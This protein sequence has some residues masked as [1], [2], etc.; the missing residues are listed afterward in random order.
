MIAAYRFFKND[1][2]AMEALQAAL[3]DPIQPQVEG[4]HVLCIQDTTEVNY[5]AHSGRLKAS[6]PELG[7]V[8]NDRDVGFFLHPSLVLDAA[9]GFALG[10][11][12]VHLWNRQWDK[13]DKH[14]RDYKRLPIEQKESFRWIEAAQQA[15]LQLKK[16]AQVTLI[17]DREADI[18]QLFSR[19]ADAQMQLLIRSR[20]E[21]RIRVGGAEGLLSEH[22]SGLDWVGEIE[23]KIRGNNGRRKR[24]ACLRVRFSRVALLRP[25]L[26]K[27]EPVDAVG[28]YVV[29]VVERAETVPSGEEPIRWC[30]LTTHCI[31][32]LADALTMIAYYRRRWQIEQ[33]FRLLKSESLELE[34]SQLAHGLALKKLCIMSLHVA[35]VQLQLVT[36][37]SGSASVAASLVFRDSALIF[38]GV[39]QSE[40]EGKTKKQ[41]CSHVEGTLAWGSWVIGRLG[42]WKGYA[43]QSPPG[44]ITMRRGLERFMSQF[45]GWQLA[46]VVQTK[47]Y[48]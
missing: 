11:A 23:I 16:A 4:K 27:Q 6:D 3:V 34:S 31:L 2:I 37:R 22:L 47:G 13:L 9:S 21:R 40:L 15:K 19:L 12:D 32:T 48:A 33:L 28:V 25:P 8:T 26:A 1:T 38:L 20:G 45:S 39:L 41:Q 24:R 46:Q 10:F 5:T 42:G 44:P 35:L 17:A 30:L 14:E 7:P 36:E 43:S 18:Y 29:E